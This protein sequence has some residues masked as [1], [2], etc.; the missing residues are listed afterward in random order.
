M[1]MAL[2]VGKNETV[3]ARIKDVMNE[4]IK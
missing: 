2:A 4:V 1:K 3:S